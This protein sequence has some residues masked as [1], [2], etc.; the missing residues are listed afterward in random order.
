MYTTY[1]LQTHCCNRVLYI[2]AISFCMD[3]L[4]LFVL[5]SV[6]LFICA[7]A[8]FVCIHGRIAFVQCITQYFFDQYIKEVK[9]FNS[10][11]GHRRTASPESFGLNFAFELLINATG[12]RRIDGSLTDGT[13]PSIPAY[14]LN[15]LTSCFIARPTSSA[16]DLTPALRRIIF[17]YELTV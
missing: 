6:C 10:S 4:P 16:L 2:Q 1:A 17:I 7:F 9:A 13:L 11:A 15:L 8:F 3:E 5:L 14:L 12:P